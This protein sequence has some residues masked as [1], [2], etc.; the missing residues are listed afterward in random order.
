[1]ARWQPKER[2]INQISRK[3]R[4]LTTLLATAHALNRLDA[5]LRKALPESMRRHIGLACLE[6][7]TLVLAATSP[8]W[9]S[10]ARLI[11]DDLLYEANQTLDRPLRR[12]RVIVVESLPDP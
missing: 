10:R 9:A 5:R 2:R 4:G 8:A 11:A 6:G 7:N 1:M 3:N 12:T